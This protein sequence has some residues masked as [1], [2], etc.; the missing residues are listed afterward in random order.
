MVIRFM[1]KALRD[2]VYVL[3]KVQY[4]QYTQYTVQV[5]YQYQYMYI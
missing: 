3:C 1:D 4:L 5:P 2:R